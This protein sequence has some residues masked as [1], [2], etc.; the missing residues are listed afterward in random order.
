MRSVTV[1][2]ALV[3]DDLINDG[4]VSVYRLSLGTEPNSFRLASLA[5]CKRKQLLCCLL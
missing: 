2:E 4:F 5:C 1:R 3:L